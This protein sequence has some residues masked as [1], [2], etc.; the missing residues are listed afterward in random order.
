MQDGLLNERD[1]RENIQEQMDSAPKGVVDADGNLIEPE[2][3]E[4]FEGYIENVIHPG[5][6][7]GYWNNAGNTD[8]ST[9]KAFETAIHQ[10]AN[11]NNLEKS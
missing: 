8:I 9:K 10:V 2:K 1:Y 11:D 4:A 7:D 3:P 6:I 5:G